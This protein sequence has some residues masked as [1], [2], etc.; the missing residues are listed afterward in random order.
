[1]L[2]VFD[3][4][5][6]FALIVI[7]FY[8]P[9]IFL[10]FKTLKQKRARKYFFRAVVSVLGRFNSDEEAA[11]QIR[12]TYHKLSERFTHIPKIYR[13]TKDFVEDFMVRID[14]LGDKD[15][16]DLYGMDLNDDQKRRLCG[17]ANMFRARDPFASVSNKFSNSLNSLS[18]A[19]TLGNKELG[20]VSLRQIADEIEVAERTIKTQ[21]KITQISV[22]VS[23]VGVI[24][25]LVFG[26]ISIVPLVIPLFSH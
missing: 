14:T 2:S 11:A 5:F 16:K 13:S 9:M 6:V 23:A 24:L 26:V 21:E 20:I 7:L 10:F 8:T 17:I 25:T 15:F 3:K 12:T 4:G 19:L 1:M 22:I 18:S